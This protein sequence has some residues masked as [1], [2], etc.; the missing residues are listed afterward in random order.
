MF[1]IYRGQAASESDQTAPPPAAPAISSMLDIEFA[2]LTDVGRVRPHNEDYLGYV[3]APTPERGRSH[4][5]LFVLADGVGGQEQGEVASHAAVESMLAN[6]NTAGGG[7]PPLG[8]LGRLVQQANG[9]VFEVAL[10]AGRAGAGMATTLV[11][12]LLRHDRVAVAHVGDSRCYLMR[13]GEM[14]S[15]TRDHT[16]ANEQV[17]LGVISRQEADEGETR[18]LLSR[19]LG[20]G[21]FVSVETGDHQIFAGDLLLLCSDGLHGA[22]PPADMQEILTGPSVNLETAARRLVEIANQ[23]DGSDNVS[24]QLIRVR[25]VERV[26]MYR[27]RPYKLR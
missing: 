11:A 5:W 23:R 4:G 18:H 17:R 7:E 26:G 12:V 8:L 22:V 19:S 13:R 10:E 15:L 16:M 27:G 6:F 3:A 24:V 20:G 25:G 21:L 2:Q 1:E 9:R 14:V